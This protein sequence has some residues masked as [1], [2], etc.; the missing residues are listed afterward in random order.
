MK[1]FLTSILTLFVIQLS[2]AQT[3]VGG[4]IYSNTTWTL[5]NSPYRMTGN[6]VV[7]PGATLTIEP[8]V[9][10]N[11]KENGNSG[12][13]YYL[14]TRGTIN[15]I[16][17]PSALI[18]FKSETAPKMVGAWKGIVVKNS[19]GGTVNY[20]YVNISNAI[21]TIAY[22]ALIPA[23]IKLHN[24]IFNYNFTAVNV[25]TELEAEN[26]SFTGNQIAMRGW[27][28]FK[29]TNCIFDSNT[30]AM[31]IYPSSLFISNCQFK[32]NQMA[33]SINSGVV[34]GVTIKN[35]FFSGNK[36]G[37][38][39]ANNGTIDSSLFSYNEEAIKN[40]TYLNIRNCGFDNNAT[41]LQVGFGST[42]K[43]CEIT[44]NKTGV[45]VG[46]INFGQPMPII[47]NNSICNNDDYNIDNRTDLNIYIPTNCFCTPDSVEIERKLLDGYDDITK[48]LI[49][50]AIYDTSCTTILNLV[51]K[52]GSTALAKEKMKKESIMVFPNPVSSKLT[53]QN[54]LPFESYK[55]S[56]LIGIEILSGSL[57]ELETTTIDVANLTPGTYI[58][59]FFGSDQKTT[60][61]KINK[62]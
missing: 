39:N 60:Y 55:I 1:L 17:T 33:L 3:N 16:G 28:T 32:G 53:V 30:A 50:Y 10:V 14:E 46:P 13:E 7:F 4:G 2:S 9:V 42:V 62:N 47:E 40:C 31:S 11:V 15:M 12:G 6:V 5:A 18:T 56:N 29:L 22:D 35:C 20:D 51:K 27:S 41:A 61:Y 58:I 26:C 59:S 8:G 36:S 34:N 44:L 25:G 37:I 21:Y 57:S 49:S 52:S 38:D 54:A 48:G 24:S 23:L 19:Q 45:A 43:E